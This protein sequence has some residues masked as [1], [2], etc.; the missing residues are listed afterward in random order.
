MNI[1]PI[2][3]LLAHHPKLVIIIFT[4]ITLLIGSQALNIYIESDLTKFLP[5]DDPAI[6][7]WDEIN[8]EFNIGKTIIILVDQTDRVYD[9]RDPKVLIE[10]DEIYI[11]IYEKLLK[12]GKETG[13]ASVNSLALLIK[14]ENRKP[15]SEGGNNYNGIPYDQNSIYKYME[16]FEIA[17]TK[18]ILYSNT[19]K[20]AVVII[21]LKD[22]ANFDQVLSR[23]EQAVENR[24][25]SYANMTI[26]G[27]IAYQDAIREESM[28]NLIIIFPVAL[29]LVSIVLFF[30]HRTLK[31]LIIAF[32]PPAFS[33]ALTFGI[34]GMVQPEL[35]IIS[36]AVV[37]LLIGLG[38]DYSI[39][40]MNRLAEEHKIEDPVKR[41][42]K[43]LRHTG[44]AVLLSTITTIIGFG[45]LMTSSMSPMATFGFGCAIGILFC[46]ISAIILVPCLAIILQFKKNGRIVIW[47]KF[48]KF[49]V[50]N[51]KRILL[52]A[53]FFAIIS[54][55]TLPEVK[56]DVNYFELA[57]KDI[58]E[59]EAMFK[60][61]ESFGGG[62]NFN[63]LLVQTD[64]NGL[65]D[66]AIIE[67]L[68]KMEDEMRDV[69]ASAF[70]YIDENK[71]EKSIYSVADEIKEVS[72][73][74][75]RSIVAEKLG[76]LMGIQKILFDMIA[77]E[78]IIDE[79]FSK[80]IILVG[81][82]ISSSIEQ[83]GEVVKEI[84]TIAASTVLPHNGQISKLTGQDAIT[85]AVNNRLTDEQIR[86][87]IL[88]LMLVLAAL[89]F[90][91]SSSTY[92]FLTMIPV[93]FVLMWEPGFLVAT[94]IP[95]SLVTISI[96]SI[97]VG[98]GID[99]GVHITHR[100]REELSRGIPK[101]DAIRIS[102]EKTGLS[103]V[104]AALTTVAGVA[105]IYFVNVP[106]LQ[107]FGIV[108][109]LMISLSCIAAAMILPVFYTSK[110]VK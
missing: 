64:P 44:K 15:I 66:P 72:D 25:T 17:A 28:R 85:I 5:K 92:G 23:T 53:G 93:I 14:K 43:I 46:F 59:V 96:A 70:P 4:I 69:I 76:E 54:L 94:D 78:G 102:I 81:I 32:L 103:L 6:Q 3:K 9:I 71:I 61:S 73:I 33:I 80:T 52:V 97:M 1:K 84:N 86:S 90:I 99:Y 65:L 68:V 60:Y 98:I 104:E 58:P 13:I 47:R 2:A 56:T 42:E 11:N 55:A 87:M 37:A 106:A 21:Q 10:M 7:L 83:I 45:S 63:A 74:I 110:S 75:N 39:H 95:L 109:I 36:V 30:F 8:Q 91:F 50:N 105:S 40:L 16:R 26:T 48:A 20:I 22:D 27:T 79:E 24:G 34:L 12:E 29:I 31:G 89:I 77:E 49:A 57:P 88:A 19:Y 51:R 41:I 82:P 100:F 107:E 67:A 35:T 38:V 18:G 62:S 108:V 101:I